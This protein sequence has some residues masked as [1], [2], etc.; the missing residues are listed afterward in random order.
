L[1]FSQ[2]G[3]YIHTHFCGG[4]IADVEFITGTQTSSCGMEDESGA[5]V[6]LPNSAF[7]QIPCCKDELKGFVTDNFLPIL[8]LIPVSFEFSYVILPGFINVGSFYNFFT[9]LHYISPPGLN[10][11]FLPFI[12]SFLF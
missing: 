4:Q 5:C 12:Q 3:I 7:S 8:K 6:N 2:A 1:F 11:V 10:S 9:S